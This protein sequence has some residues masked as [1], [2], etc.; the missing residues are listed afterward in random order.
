MTK[1]CSLFIGSASESVDYANALQR[2]L[3]LELVTTLWR[4]GVFHPTGN[5]LES[6]VRHAEATDFAALFLT[7]DDSSVVRGEYLKTPRDNVLFELGLFIGRLRPER[8]FL[9]TPNEGVDLPS[10]LQGVTTISY[11]TDRDDDDA[12]NAVNPAATDIRLAVKH[13]GPRPSV[14]SSAAGA[15]S[16]VGALEALTRLGAVTSGSDVSLRIRPAGALFEIVLVDN[17]RMETSV[18][19]DLADSASARAI[20][21]L[22]E[23]LSSDLR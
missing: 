22:G 3:H 20:D 14:E 6:L 21:G 23:T 7:P 4:Y 15:R 8:V 5:T 19:I 17:T 9:L 10:D 11:R 16:S 2:V 18:I 13:L 12:Q 1:Q